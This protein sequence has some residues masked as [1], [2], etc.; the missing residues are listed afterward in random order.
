MSQTRSAWAVMVKLLAEYN[1]EECTDLALLTVW[2]GVGLGE[3]L[4]GEGAFEYGV[5]E[6]KG[7][8]Q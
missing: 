6:H 3:L 1:D 4:V 2:A 5:H 8:T 7:G